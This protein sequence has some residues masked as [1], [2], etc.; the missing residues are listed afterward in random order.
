MHIIMHLVLM[1]INIFLQTWTCVLSLLLHIFMCVRWCGLEEDFWI[2]LKYWKSKIETSIVM[3]QAH[4]QTCLSIT[5]STLSMNNH[6][7]EGWVC[8]SDFYSVCMRALLA[9]IDTNKNKVIKFLFLVNR[10]C[11]WN[12]ALYTKWQWWT[13]CRLFNNSLFPN[14]FFCMRGDQIVLWLHKKNLFC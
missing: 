14:L 4:V 13:A 5:I 12:R 3:F 7:N 11:I 1:H 10:I 9:T 8:V 2:F 6:L